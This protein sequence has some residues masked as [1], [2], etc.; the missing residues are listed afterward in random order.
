MVVDA[1]DNQTEHNSEFSFQTVQHYI[2]NSWC[3]NA[4]IN[5]H[6]SSSKGHQAL[7]LL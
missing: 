5:Y 1:C 3:D 4:S 6:L 7:V 2:S